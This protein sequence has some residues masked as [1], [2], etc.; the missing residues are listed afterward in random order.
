[1]TIDIIRMA[2]AYS[3]PWL[4]TGADPGGQD[5]PPPFGETPMFIKRKKLPRIC[6]RKHH[7]L[8]LNK[9]QKGG[10][11]PGIAVLRRRAFACN[12]SFFF[13]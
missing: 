9:F 12:V 2:L 10:G 6:A 13:L 8:V 11:G 7:V 1:M 3:A 4:D 5:P